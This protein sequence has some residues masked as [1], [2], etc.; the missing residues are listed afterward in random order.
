MPVQ[1]LIRKL[2]RAQIDK[3]VADSKAKLTV[4]DQSGATLVIVTA[5]M[6]GEGK[7]PVANLALQKICDMDAAVVQKEREEEAAKI[8][9]EKRAKLAAEA[10]KAANNG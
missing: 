10:A 2:T 1:A 7:D 3:V 5:T 6:D 4:Q 9:A 8:A